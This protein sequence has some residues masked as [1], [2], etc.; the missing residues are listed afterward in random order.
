MGITNL[1][2][3]AGGV[4]LGTQIGYRAA[5]ALD[6]RPL[7]HQFSG[8][9]DHPARL[10]LRAPAQTAGVFGYE[11]GMKVVEVGCGT[12]TFTVEM[13]RLVGSTGRVHAVDLQK[14]M[15]DK[16][17]V[18]VTGAGLADRVR[19][20]HRGAYRLPMQDASMDLAVLMA[21][22]S[23]IPD[24]ALALAEIHRVLK[25][26][27]RLVVGEEIFLPAYLPPKSVRSLVEAAGFRFGGHQGSPVCYTTI[28]FK[29]P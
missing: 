18:R 27:A 3:L 28:F 14:S 23:E 5:C 22:L 17:H 4:A 19:F 15:I 20:E 9:L 24:R 12:G 2:S 13:A 1:L 25:P 16:A 8:L 21:V 7:P 29:E 10:K 6:P 26:E 11:P